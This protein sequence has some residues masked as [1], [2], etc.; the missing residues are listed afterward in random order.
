MTS[1]SVQIETVKRFYPHDDVVIL[2]ETPRIPFT[3]GIRMLK[4]SGWTEED[5]RE[6]S[7]YEDLSTRAEQRLGQLVK[8]KYG[9]D[10]Y[11]IDKFPLE[12][13]PFYTMPDPENDVSVCSLHGPCTGDSQSVTEIVELVRLLPTRRG[14]LVRRTARPCRGDARRAHEGSRC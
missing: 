8:E 7:E 9:A 1:P 3:E 12:V 6:L 2:D 5:G 11:I 4:E 10:Y 14:D 13:R